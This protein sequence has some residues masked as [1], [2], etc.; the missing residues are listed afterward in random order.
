MC[1]KV[2]RH[3]GFILFLFVFIHHRGQHNGDNRV[4]LGKTL[5]S[6]VLSPERDCHRS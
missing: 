4:A 2:E 3:M 6:L 5:S 1:I